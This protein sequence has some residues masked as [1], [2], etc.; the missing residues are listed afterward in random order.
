MGEAAAYPADLGRT[1]HSRGGSGRAR[2]W[3]GR[4]RTAVSGAAEL[5]RGVDGGTRPWRRRRISAAEELGCVGRGGARGTTGGGAAGRRRD[6]TWARPWD[7]EFP[8][9]GLSGVG[10]AEFRLPKLIAKCTR[11]L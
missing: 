6:A 1:G 3:R 2:P 11:G 7:P 10:K 8:L 5:G 4:R 9:C